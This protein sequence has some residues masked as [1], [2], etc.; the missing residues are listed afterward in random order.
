V[1]LCIPKLTHAIPSPSQGRGSVTAVAPVGDEVFV[2]R[3]KSQEVEVYDAEKI[4]LKCHIAVPG[5]QHARGLA[6]CPNNSCLYASDLFSDSVH[7]VELKAG[8]AAK[9]WSV[10]GRST[11]L[12]VNKANNL[13]VACYGANKLQEYTTHGSIW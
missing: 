8:N 11:S 4:A 3:N 5:L 1:K 13:V 2:L 6:V 10:S 9:K 12:S 7:R